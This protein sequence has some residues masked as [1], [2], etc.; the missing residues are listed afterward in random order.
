MI[1]LLLNVAE[2]LRSPACPQTFCLFISYEEIVNCF[3]LVT[4][5]NMGNSSDATKYNSDRRIQIFA[6]AQVMNYP[7]VI[8]TP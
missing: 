5:Q 6:W 1:Q 2:P 3:S 4:V 8:L 7:S